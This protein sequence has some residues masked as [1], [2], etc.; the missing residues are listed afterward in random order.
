MC[1]DYKGGEEID[2]VWVEDL[3]VVLVRKV[4]TDRREE[5]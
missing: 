1:L 5:G 3:M 2:L 4:D